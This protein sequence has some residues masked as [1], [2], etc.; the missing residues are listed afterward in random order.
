MPSSCP[1]NV[2]DCDSIDFRKV[3]N[4]LADV[5]PKIGTLARLEPKLAAR[6]AKI[7]P[8]KMLGI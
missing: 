2:T 6:S 4:I 8:G 7:R 5:N 1:S 3:A